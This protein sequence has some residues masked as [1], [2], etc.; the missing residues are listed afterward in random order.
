MIIFIDNISSFVNYYQ[1]MHKQPMFQ[2]CEKL[3]AGITRDVPVAT[4][5]SGS[6]LWAQVWARGLIFCHHNYGLVQDYLQL[7]MGNLVIYGN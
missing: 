5:W 2:T 6:L 7:G 3:S 1:C 4:L